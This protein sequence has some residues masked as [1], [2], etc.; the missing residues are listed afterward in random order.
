LPP[1]KPGPDVLLVRGAIIDI[2]SRVPPQGPGRSDVYLDSVGQATFVIELIDSETSTVLARATDTR[3]AETPGYTLKANRVTNTA[4]VRKLAT[5][6]ASLLVD[7][8]NTITT[9]PSLNDDTK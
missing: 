8:L 5:Y 6:W 1:H 9:L 2:V 7:A 4:E 3:A